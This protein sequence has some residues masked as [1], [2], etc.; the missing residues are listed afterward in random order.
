MFT[1][2]T[3][4][5]GASFN[6]NGA[7]FSSLSGVTDANGQATVQYTAGTTA[8]ADT[9][10][11]VATSTGVT[12]ST[13][14][15][16]TAPSGGAV[17]SAIT[18][19]SVANGAT[20]PVIANGVNA[21][22]IRATVQGSSGPLSGSTVTFT[23]TAGTFAASVTTAEATT[24]ASGIATVNLIAPTSP[25]TATVTASASGFSASTT[26]TFVAGAAAVVQLVANP[27]TVNPNAT[28]SITARVT[29]AQG[30]PVS[31]QTL[32]FTAPSR[33]TLSALT[34]ITDTNGQFAVTYTAG[35]TPATD[36]IQVRTVNGITGTLSITI[37]PASG[38][39]RIDL[40]VSSPQLGSNGIGSV[41][42]TALV[43][44]AANNVVSGGL[45]SFAADSGNIQVTNGITAVDGTA[46]AI[47]STRGN[48]QNRT[49]TVT[50]T[51]ES[52][53]ST[54]TVEVVG[55]TLNVSGA[56]RLVLG[57][58]TRLTILLQ[59]SGRV[60]IQNHPITIT[61][62]LGNP[63]S[64]TMVMTDVS[65]QATVD[66]TAS[67]SGTDI[68]Q[69]TASGVAP[70]TTTLLISADNFV[71]RLPAPDAQVPLN[72]PQAVTMHWDQAGVNQVGQTI[73]FFATRGNFTT[74]LTCPTTTVAIISAI[75]NASGDATVNICSDNAGPSV[76]SA[77]ANVSSGP[78]SQVEIEFV[79]TI[80]AL[81]ILH[82]TVTS[83]APN[84][85]S[86]ITAVVR[87]AQDNLVKNQT[88]SFSVSDVSAGQ[89][90]P[91]F[92]ITDSFGRASTVFTA[93]P[94]TSGH[95]SVMITASTALGTVADTISLTVAQQALFVVLGTAN[96][97][98]PLSPTQYALPYSV[99]V[100]DANGT[101]VA[102]AIV[103]LDIVPT[104]YRKGICGTPTIT[105]P[106]EDGL[107]DPNLTN[108]IRDLNPD[109]DINGNNSLDPGNV[110]AVPTTVSTDATGFAFFDVVYAQEFAGL[111]EVDLNASTVVVGSERSSQARFFLPGAC[112]VPPGSFRCGHD[113]Y[114]QR[115]LDS[116]DRIP[117]YGGG[118]LS[119]RVSG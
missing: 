91:G 45:V 16:V 109:E 118:L 40:F 21:V 105:C 80:P 114:R 76:I 10:R 52:L 69:V 35:A 58:T 53:S 111:V 73:N 18:S 96:Q 98:Q 54:S 101:P 55:T 20:G 1:F 70:T 46:T 25:G 106:N 68:I 112:I 72:A 115:I 34:G 36:T 62:S 24:N 59:D 94:V 8:G 81:L 102:N 103:A 83:L 90:A 39:S 38:A 78:S 56:T 84:Q 97:V 74:T 7:S 110:A 9:V 75:T 104:Q 44:N 61:S 11:V 100:T 51:T 28:S 93:S 4:T 66:V 87:D 29:D 82:A 43:R 17:S 41:T 50:A 57:A 42:L 14:I 79:A 77:A 32:T 99:L 88:V 85:Q 119:W 67:F 86:I 107:F 49:I 95:E 3:N 12:G 6:S 64:A 26:I 60:G 108:G 48:P 30:N 89:I 47:L 113:L 63:L 37:T 71:I 2:S 33:G 13:S 31:A 23:T 92:G 5:S 116:V 65:G 27:T 22:A 15:T 117:C 19:I